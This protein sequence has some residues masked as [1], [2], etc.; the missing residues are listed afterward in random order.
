MRSDF[1]D[2]R[3]TKQLLRNNME[4]FFLTATFLGFPKTLVKACA[5]TN[6]NKYKYK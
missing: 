6:I 1:S 5:L 4:G 2:L 3:A